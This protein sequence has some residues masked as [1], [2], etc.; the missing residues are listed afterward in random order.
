VTCERKVVLSADRT[1][2]S[3][4]GN[5]LFYGFFSTAP[6]KRF[7]LISPSAI[8]RFIL[9]KVPTDA[10]GRAK[11]APQGLRRVESSLISS[12][13]LSAGEVAVTPPE[14][15]G[16]II[17]SSTRVIGIAAIDPLGRGPSS[18]TF[19][20]DYGAVHEEPMNAFHFRKLMGSD[21]LRRARRLGAKVIVGGPGAWQLGSAEMA[22]Y[23]I[24]VVIEG[25]A[26]LLFPS[27][28]K[29]A[30]EG[31]LKTPAIIK[32]DRGM[33][34]EAGQIPL[35]MG[36]T[37]GGLVEIS[38]GCGRGCKF[39]MP[40]LRK[41]RHRPMDD[42]IADVR[43]N[44]A[45]GVKCVCFHAEDA[46]R[47]GTL[48]FMP[49]QAKVVSLFEAVKGIRGVEDIS[50][51]HCALASI[52]S[53]PQTVGRVTDVLGLDRHHWMGF[54]T[55]IETGSPNMIQRL[56]NMKPAPFK[57]EE[58]HQ[59]VESAFAI[60]DDNNWVPAA[61]IMV[62]MPGETEDDVIK[63][64]E[65]IDSLYE[66]R[67]LIVPL[68]YAPFADS[69][70]KPMRLVEDAKRCHFELYRSVWKHDMHWLRDIADDYRK[71]SSLPT[72]IAVSVLVRGMKSYIDPKARAYFD[73]RIEKL[74]REEG[75]G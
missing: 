65:L 54:Q 21:A 51:S 19:G 49:D 75:Q 1:V 71:T 11:M 39:C 63:S 41:V 47:Y 60:C 50:V 9:H 42:I 25:E 4:Y 22:E 55:G 6:N 37:I 62:N 12:G 73:R 67:S 33:I 57:P 28:V 43:T 23:G 40:T 56:M 32:P 53:S 59:V 48:G 72:R 2:M 68:L 3:S 52:A 38:R 70:V 7:W 13:I 20:G 61:T 5:S 27:V 44:I 30:L 18:T 36:G 26:D 34:P 66:Y 64:V 15:L 16:R 58:W 29:S 17:T 46:L 45:S 74:R 35:L 14:N 8:T 31:T 69:N 24:D 10:E